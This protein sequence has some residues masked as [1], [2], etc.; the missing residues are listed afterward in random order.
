MR[1]TVDLQEGFAGQEVRITAGGQQLF[2]KAVKT[3]HQIGL[4][5]RFQFEPEGRDQLELRVELVGE[6]S[7]V[8]IALPAEGAA[9][10]GIS[11]VDGRL[12]ARVSKEPFQ[13][14]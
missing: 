9:H 2:R 13:Y 12:E 4:A 5:E 8:R 10:V 6:G 7:Q 14:A 11:L 3:R 1:V